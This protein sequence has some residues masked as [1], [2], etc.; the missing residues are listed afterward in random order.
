MRI[1]VVD[2]TEA[3]LLL[4][5]RFVGALGH[6]AI[7]ARNGL[8]A[9]EVWRKERPELVLMDIMMPVMS[10][11]EAAVV[12]KDEAGE[13]WVPIVFVTGVGEENTLAEA[14]ERAAD[15][16][17]HKPVNF[18]VLEAKLKA[19]GRTLE[20][21]RKVREQSAKLADY[22]DRA[23]EEKRVVRHLM[24][25]MVNAD[26]LADP[27]LEY[28]LTPAESLS[29]DLIAAARTPGT[30]LHVMLADGIGHGITAA[31]NV[32]PLTQ[33]FYSMTEKGYAIPDILVEMND[34]IRQVLPVGR[35]VAVTLL[36]INEI[37][38]CIEIWNGGMPELQVLNRA[39]EVVHACKSFSLPL[40]VVP[41]H[42]MDFM[43]ERFYFSEPGYVLAYSDGLIEARNAQ[44]QEFGLSR[45]M[46]RL[47]GSDAAARMHSVQQSFADFLG[48]LPHHDDV[49]MVLASFGE[50]R[51]VPTQVA[52]SGEAATI[53]SRLPSVAAEDEDVLWRYTL[54]LGAN[55]LKYV[56][57]VPFMMSFVSSIHELARNASD[58][59][60]ILNELFVNALDHGVLG[61]ESTLKNGADGMEQYLLERVRRLSDLQEGRIEI[62]L[63]GL[64]QE[65]GHVL[66][67]CVKD[68]GAGF[69][70]QRIRE[71]D[72]LKQAY[73]RGIALVQSLCVS[74]QYHGSGNEAIAYYVPH[75]A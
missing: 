45:L 63:I 30:I 74:L 32:L 75:N 18:R 64:Q 5:T 71:R 49:S 11:P 29:G 4:M 73:G 39:G 26:R 68:S 52:V 70:W 53:A 41:S 16:Y 6:E 38:G 47:Q 25:Q 3:M 40:G 33:P 44:G 22:Y 46:E 67:V 51:C 48:G 23:E 43:P 54:I 1:L 58:I 10:G 7:P 69:D 35:F 36:A 20:L 34:K 17:I 66:R 2:D 31:L 24:E 19:F 42:V 14:I 59:F 13:T 8:E 72:P 28:W 57:T 55:E 65:T 12:I 50:K 56:N 15:D 60:L 27:S 37:D 9:V 21:N 61:L 62:D